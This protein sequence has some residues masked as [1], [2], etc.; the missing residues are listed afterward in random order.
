MVC[1]RAC[2]HAYEPSIVSA[3][4]T[5]RQHTHS[6]LDRNSQRNPDVEVL[7]GVFKGPETHSSVLLTLRLKMDQGPVCE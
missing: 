3:E 6:S 1:V 2:V 4:L 5:V 7:A